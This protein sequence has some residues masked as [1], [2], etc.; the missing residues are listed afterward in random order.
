M[1]EQAREEYEAELYSE[2]HDELV[3]I[4]AKQRDFVMTTPKSKKKRR[5]VNDQ[6]EN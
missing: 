3:K 1:T 4:R 5:L 6:T 2:L